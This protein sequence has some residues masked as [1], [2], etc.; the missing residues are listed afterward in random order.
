LKEACTESGKSLEDRKTVEKICK[1]SVCIGSSK[2]TTYVRKNA[3]AL[4]RY[5]ANVMEI[6]P[7]LL[8]KL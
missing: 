8:E 4:G 2:A 5:A 3:D 1:D 6:D 7:G